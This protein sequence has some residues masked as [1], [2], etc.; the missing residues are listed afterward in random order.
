LIWTLIMFAIAI[1][2]PA[3]PV[4][5]AALYWRRATAPAAVIATVAGVATV[6]L[7]YQYGYGNNWYGAFGLAVSAVLMIVISLVT[8][9]TDEKVLD[10]FYGALD[11][12][13]I[14]HYAAIES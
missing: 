8:P 1:V 12:A 3:F 9:K 4:L 7:T 2:M 6:L 11:E 13:E 5:V 10:E 14:E